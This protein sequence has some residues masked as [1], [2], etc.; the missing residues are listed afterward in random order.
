MKKILYVLLAIVLVAISFANLVPLLGLAISLVVLYFSVKQFSATDSTLGKV[1][2]GI[3]GM[4]ATI[5]AVSNLPAVIGLIA[6]Y[7]LYVLYKGWKQ[8]KE[9]PVN[10]DPFQQ[11]EQQWNEIKNKHI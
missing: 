11:F 2:W 7:L 8:E 6:L 1:F 3:I 10:G 5:N 9:G 4:I